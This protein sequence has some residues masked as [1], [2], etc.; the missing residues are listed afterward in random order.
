[1]ITFD[2]FRIVHHSPQSNDNSTI[3]T[4]QHLRRPS[5]KGG[6]GKKSHHGHEHVVKVEVTV[7]PDPLLHHGKRCIPIVVENVGTSVI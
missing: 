5:F 7:V 2:T 4:K 1:M 6:D 3:Y